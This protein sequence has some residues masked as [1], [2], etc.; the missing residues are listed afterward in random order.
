M[1][2]SA[3]VQAIKTGTRSFADFSYAGPITDGHNLVAISYRMG[4]VGLAW[5]EAAKRITNN[6]AANKYLTREYRT[7]WD[8]ARV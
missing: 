7:G 4:G 5:D 1:R 6:E 3:L 2:P 8:P